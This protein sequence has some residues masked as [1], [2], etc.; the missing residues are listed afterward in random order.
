MDG[1]VA[2]DGSKSKPRGFA[3]QTQTECQKLWDQ[4]KGDTPIRGDE[5]DV[6]ILIVLYSR[7]AE[8]T[9][10][11]FQRGYSLLFV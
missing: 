1:E 8:D 9:A 4:N 5:V 3:P 6:F 11:S 7:T 2:G 10:I